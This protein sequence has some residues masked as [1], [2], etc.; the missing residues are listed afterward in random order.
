MQDPDTSAKESGG[1]AWQVFL[2]ASAS[3]FGPLMVLADANERP[4]LLTFSF[5]V[6]A[7]AATGV[8]AWLLM[9]RLGLDG[10]GSAYAI[11]AF[12]LIVMNFGGWVR[13]GDVDRLPLLLAA[14]TLGAL[15]YRLRRV[16]LVRGLMTWAA[17]F[18]V[19]YPLAI[20]G[21]KALTSE[22]LN[23]E[24]SASLELSAM[25][26]KPDIL[27]VV[28]DA[29]GGRNVLSEFYG[30]D[31]G[32]FLEELEGLGFEAPGEVL[33]NYGR[34]QLSVP[35]VLQLD[36]V[37]GENEVT[38]DD[39]QSL[40]GVLA[41][42]SRLSS[43]LKAQGYR[44]VQVESGW[45]GS[46]C[47]PDVDVCI[48]APWPDETFYDAAYRSI[49][50]GLP[51]LELGRPFTN[52]ALNAAD[53]LMN[54]TAPF[55]ADDRP[56]YIFA[57][58]LLPHPPLFLNSE[59]EPDWRGGADGFSIGR[60]GFDA[61]QTEQVRSLYIEQVE[62][63]NSLII[64]IARRLGSD[65]AALIMGDHGPDSQ[66]QLFIQSADWTTDQRAERFDAF[67]A[68]KVPGCDMSHIESLV[69]VGRRMISC[70]SGDPYPDLP[71]H[72]FD[73]HKSAEENRV[74]E[75]EIP[76]EFVFEVGK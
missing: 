63:A 6:A 66:A 5:T 71:T 8:V 3:A 20:I 15:A 31:N 36:Y 46:R 24:T 61:E 55:L 76:S 52:G 57:H 1:K 49:A 4:T 32:P 60:T 43:A 17:L 13:T 64:D 56:D 25:S 42:R 26:S 9:R 39:I 53:W 70:L 50:V 68:T 72:I 51:G 54:D 12:I 27:L 29:Y 33:A 48:P 40:L 22:P 45:L 30:Y 59:C 35:T 16:T 67:L 11:A 19:A 58:V 75:L 14:I 47:G 21:G 10:L 7:I 74:V 2:I 62:C 37:S 73:I 38:D 69:N 18:L 23:V 44:T 34:T 28:M 41:G 65:D